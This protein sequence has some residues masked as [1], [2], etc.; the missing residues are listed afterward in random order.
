[1]QDTIFNYSRQTSLPTFLSALI[2]ANETV[3]KNASNIPICQYMFSS[4]VKNL[5][6]GAKNKNNFS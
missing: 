6:T 5:D 3:K 2:K 4:C 1:M